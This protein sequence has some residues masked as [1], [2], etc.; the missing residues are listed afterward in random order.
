V[1][2][3]EETV[4]ESVGEVEETKSVVVWWVLL[5]TVHCLFETTE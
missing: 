3:V 2:E 1:G 4:R 5:L